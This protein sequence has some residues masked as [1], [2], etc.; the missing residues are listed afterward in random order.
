MNML[1]EFYMNKYIDHIE[2][3]VEKQKTKA[4]VKFASFIS[5][6]NSVDVIAR[7]IAAGFLEENPDAMKIIDTLNIDKLE[8][9]SLID[10]ELFKLNYQQ[11]TGQKSGNLC[12]AF[13]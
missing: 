8:V 9:L 13:S 7:I 10:D 6:P 2:K 3:E 4:L 11:V 5:Q 1:Y 12:K